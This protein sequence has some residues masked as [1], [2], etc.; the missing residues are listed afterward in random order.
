MV[1]KSAPS[2]GGDLP[3]AAALSPEK[4][5]A[6]EPPRHL[7]TPLPPTSPLLHAPFLFTSTI[8]SCMRLLALETPP[9]AQALAE[10]HRHSPNPLFTSIF[11]TRNLRSIRMGRRLFPQEQ[12]AHAIDH[13]ADVPKGHLRVDNSR[14]IQS[15][16][17]KTLR[18]HAYIIQGY[19][20]YVYVYQ[21]V[22][23]VGYTPANQSSIAGLMA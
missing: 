23:S 3:T 22:L 21:R 11:S 9:Q 4:L 15:H 7:D 16:G 20:E 12:L 10:I 14:I 1:A 18:D 6:S 17:P 13:G 5:P 2:S 8:A 19:V